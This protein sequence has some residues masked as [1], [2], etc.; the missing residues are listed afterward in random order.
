VIEVA[1]AEQYQRL[2][3]GRAR[4]ATKVEQQLQARHLDARL[5]TGDAAPRELKS[6]HGAFWDA[7][8]WQS[9]TAFMVLPPI[10][11]ITMAVARQP[12]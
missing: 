5:E 12:W 9:C 6:A 4:A 2:V 10:G 11:T 1:M 3:H 7:W 8:A